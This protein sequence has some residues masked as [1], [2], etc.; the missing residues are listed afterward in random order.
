MP[1]LL[2]VFIALNG[3]WFSPG[4]CSRDISP[5]HISENKK[6]SREKKSQRVVAGGEDFYIIH[7]N[8][9]P[10][11]ISY[12]LTVLSGDEAFK[13]SLFP[14]PNFLSAPCTLCRELDWSF[15]SFSAYFSS[16]LPENVNVVFF[17]SFFHIFSNVN[18][19]LDCE[20]SFCSGSRKHFT[21]PR[22][23]LRPRLFI[24]RMIFR[25]KN[26]PGFYRYH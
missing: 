20:L 22:V 5:S 7:E 6:K 13:K 10:Q 26:L 24:C 15:E 1:A 2:R 9:Y 14:Y 23:F 18:G 25:H 17:F 3:L 16:L 12:D 21:R 4:G 11:G 19:F 8:C